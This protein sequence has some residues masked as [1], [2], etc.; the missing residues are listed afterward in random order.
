MMVRLL[1]NHFFVLIFLSFLGEKTLS[2]RGICRYLQ[3]LE[4]NFCLVFDY[5]AAFASQSD[6]THFFVAATWNHP[7][8]RRYRY[9][10]GKGT[11]DQQYQCLRGYC[12]CRPHHFGSLR[13]G[14]VDL[15]WQLHHRLQR[16]SHR[17]E[18]S[19]YCSP[20]C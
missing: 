14:Q 2:K 6:L 10:S 17:F 13:Y 12:R 8:A 4:F 1:C 20:R 7:P 18:G 3:F 9:F 11:V 15:H 19:R 5:C 16:W